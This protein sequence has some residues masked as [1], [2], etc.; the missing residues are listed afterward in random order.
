MNAH[1]NIFSRPHHL[2]I[3]IKEAAVFKKEKQLKV[4]RDAKINHGQ[5]LP[6]LPS[7]LIVLP[8]LFFSE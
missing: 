4:F 8:T 2:N 7:S 6:T 5:G 1:K 3:S